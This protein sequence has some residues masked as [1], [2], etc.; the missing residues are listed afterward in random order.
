MFDLVKRRP[1]AVAAI[2]SV[3]L[4]VRLGY[5]FATWPRH[6]PFTDALFY[7]LQANALADGKG[8]VQPVMALTGRD[9]PSAAHPPLY[10]LFLAAGSALGARSVLAHEIMGCLLGVLTVVAAGL[11]GHRLAGE[12][13]GLVVMGLAAIYPP[14]WVTD[15]GVMAEGLYTLLTAVIILAGYRLAERRRVGDACVL[16]AAVGLATL[17]R[18]EAVLLL[19]VLVLPIAWTVRRDGRRR[20]ARLFGISLA[21]W[22]I[23]V[24]PWVGRNLV[25]FHHPVTLSTGDQTLLGANCPPAYYG[26][27]IGTWY[28]SCYSHVS[29]TPGLDE[30]DVAAAAQRSGLRYIRSHTLRVP[31]VVAARVARVWQVY[32]PVADAD[33]DLD[34]GRPRWANLAGLYGYAAL[35]PLAV[36]GLLLLVRRGQ[37]VLPLTAQLVAV[38]VTAAAVWGAIRFRTPADVVIVVLAGVA[39]SAWF[40]RAGRAHGQAG[41]LAFRDHGRGVPYN[42]SVPLEGRSAR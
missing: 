15:G 19:V 23:V 16:G 6:L 17:T 29:R 28:L 21:G 9:V 25:T 5:V 42:A 27:G 13:A 37:R 24:S 38:T 18:A 4:A 11:I 22:A 34:D 12:R 26:R 2:A 20:A 3:A 14:L 10:P 40:E 32:Q 1:K 8:F 31:V 41:Q 7:Q 39:L 30:S 35:V 33:N 36:A